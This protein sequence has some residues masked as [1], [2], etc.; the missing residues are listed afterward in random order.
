MPQ[1]PRTSREMHA[2]SRAKEH[3]RARTGDRSLARAAEARPC[4]TTSRLPEGG[5]PPAVPVRTRVP[6]NSPRPCGT[7]RPVLKAPDLQSLACP[8]PCQAARPC[9]SRKLKFSQKLPAKFHQIMEQILD[10]FPHMQTKI[11]S[12]HMGES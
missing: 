12:M 4:Y 2:P 5:T 6:W 3:A 8:R 7:A 9:Q 10:N 11:N 1:M